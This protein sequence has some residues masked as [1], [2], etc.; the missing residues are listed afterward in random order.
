MKPRVPLPALVTGLC[1]LLLLTLLVAPPRKRPRG[2]HQ[3]P[4]L[5]RQEMLRLVGRGYIQLIADYFWLQL[6]Q[7]T[8]AARG[9]DEYRD[10]YAYADL[11]TDLDPQFR[12]VYTFAA[13]VLPTNTGRE[14][15][16]NTAESTL[17]LRKGLKLFPSDLKMNMLLAYNLSAFHKQYREAAE[18]VERTAK[19]PGAPA[20]LPALATRLYAQSG[21]VD[22]GEALALALAESAEDE[23]TRELF[24]TRVRDLRL[25]RELRRVDAALAT[26]RGVF[27]ASPPDLATLLWLGYLDRPPEDPQGGA[28][29]IGYDGRARSETQQ[30]RMDI[31]SAESRG[32]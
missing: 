30:K 24:L 15:W 32:G 23:E 13:G 9:A 14:I 27:G 17:L 7:T 1:G 4:L 29:F 20:Y 11:I 6:I 26:F 21:D 19:L 12:L 8:G 22:T 28:F 25:E 10:L 18:V 31:F 16:A 2:P 5:P 3:E